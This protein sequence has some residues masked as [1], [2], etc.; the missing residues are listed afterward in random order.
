MERVSGRSGYVEALIR[1][2]THIPHIFNV[3]HKKSLRR[4]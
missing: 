1:K 3:L 4:N 2:R